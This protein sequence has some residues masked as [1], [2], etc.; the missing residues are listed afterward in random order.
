MKIK[1]IFFL[2][3]LFIINAC[4]SKPEPKL[5]LFSAEAFAYDLGDYWEV[6]TTVNAKGFAQSEKDN[7]YEAKLSYSIDLITTEDD[8]IKSIF[9]DSIDKQNNELM[10]DIAL[11]AQLEVDSTF[12]EGNYKIIFKVTDEISKQ[13]KSLSINF[14]LEK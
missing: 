9:N 3:A 2:V 13:T 14:N 10:N 5:E 12:A 1:Q 8:T 11:E 4:S 7:K 6:N